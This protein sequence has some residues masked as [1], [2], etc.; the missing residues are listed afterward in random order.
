MYNGNATLNF[1]RDGQPTVYIGEQAPNAE[2]PVVFVGANRTRRVSANGCELIILRDNG[3]PSWVEVGRRV[4]HI[5]TAS[6]P[7]R[8]AL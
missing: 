1:E 7:E 2:V 6:L 3:S 5:R 8:T 4:A